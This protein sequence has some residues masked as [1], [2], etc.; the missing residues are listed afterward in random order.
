MQDRGGRRDLC[1]S[2]RSTFRPEDVKLPDNRP[3]ALNGRSGSRL[4]RFTNSRALFGSVQG[5]FFLKK[6]PLGGIGFGVWPL[7]NRYSRFPSPTWK[8]TRGE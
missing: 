8:S 1:S 3:F 5:D 7:E 6:K 2:R 4:E